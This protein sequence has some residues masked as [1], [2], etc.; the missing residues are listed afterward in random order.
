MNARLSIESAPAPAPLASAIYEGVVRH[1]RMGPHPHS[2][3]YKMAQVYLDLDE[4]NTIDLPTARAR[5][6]E[7]LADQQLMTCLS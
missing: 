4:I 3:D 2:F 6:A 7:A 5:T 1:R